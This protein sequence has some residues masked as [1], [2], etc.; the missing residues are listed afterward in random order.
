MTE[1]Q[2]CYHGAEPYI[3]T[4]LGRRFYPLRDEPGFDIKEIAHALSMKCRYTGHSAR[5]YSVAEHCVLVA[6]IMRMFVL[7]DPL[8]GLLHEPEAYLPDVASPYK[9]LLPDFCKLEKEVDR[10]QRKHFGLPEVGTPGCKVADWVALYVE[11]SYLIP[12]LLN[13]IPPAEGQVAELVAEFHKREP[14]IELGSAPRYAHDM[15]LAEYNQLSTEREAL[16]N[17]DA[18][19]GVQ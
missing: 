2:G 17:V 18:A 12:Q 7:G 16:R 4:V 13:D 6:H 11:A 19:G 5:F 1:A 9:A 10:K 15:F 14:V 8:E 3:T